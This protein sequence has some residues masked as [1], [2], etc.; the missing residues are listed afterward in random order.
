MRK[1]LNTSPYGSIQDFLRPGA[2]KVYND[3]S[4]I[5]QGDIMTTQCLEEIV[6]T[7]PSTTLVAEIQTI[8]VQFRNEVKNA[9]STLYRGLEELI[10]YVSQVTNSIRRPLTRGLIIS[11]IVLLVVTQHSSAVASE[12]TNKAWPSLYSLGVV[13]EEQIEAATLPDIFSLSHEVINY[14]RGVYCFYQRVFYLA[15]QNRLGEIAE[16]TKLQIQVQHSYLRLLQNLVS[17]YANPETV[18]NYIHDPI[19][20]DQ[21]CNEIQ[22]TIDRLDELARGLREY[23]EKKG[24]ECP[25]GMYT[26]AED[27]SET[28]IPRAYLE[29]VVPPERLL[30]MLKGVLT[31]VEQVGQSYITVYDTADEGINSRGKN[32][33]NYAR[34]IRYSQN[35]SS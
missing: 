16:S 35:K 29:A 28:Q 32:K 14:V 24:I 10:C 27:S 20:R 17:N 5:G 2:Q 19:A 4:S 15:S 30:G 1:G 31:Y 9:G 21:L 25:E 7:I 26:I 18:S 13:E 12:A 22:P 3:V 34:K 6:Y 33:A 8:L 23:M 11:L